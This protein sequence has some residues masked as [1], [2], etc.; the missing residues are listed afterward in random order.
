[1]SLPATTRLAPAGATGP[2]PA[3]IVRWLAARGI[4]L[5]VD[6]CN[7]RVRSR[8]P[9]PTDVRE[10]LRAHKPALLAHL[11][12]VRQA[13]VPPVRIPEQ[14][15]RLPVETTPPT[16]SA[17]RP[18]APPTPTPLLTTTARGV[19]DI[20]EVVA[21]WKGV[22]ALDTE[23]TGLDPLTHRVRL[24]Q[25]ALGDDVAVIDLFAV[26][27]P[28]ALAPLFEALAGKEVVA[29]NLQFDIRFLAPLGFTPAGCSTR[30]SPRASFTLVGG[31]RTT[32]GLSTGWPKSSSGN[33]GAC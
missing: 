30:C 6:G 22:V 2:A 25:V 7:L 29:H 18:P 12:P 5:A 16:V 10:R 21:G 17:A 31:R 19:A 3:A 32:P 24:I 15:R 28:A 11:A 26:P 23:T 9:I 1:M 33:S 14:T 20:A 13:E 4:E 27:D 8:R